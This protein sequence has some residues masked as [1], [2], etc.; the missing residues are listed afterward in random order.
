LAL[1]VRVVGADFAIAAK[2]IEAVL[3]EVAVEKPRKEVSRDEMKRLWE[4]SQPL[5][6]T[7]GE[8]YFRRRGLDSVPSCLR[9]TTKDDEGA[10]ILARV[11]GPTGETVNLHRTFIDYAGMKLP[12]ER[13][14][15]MMPHK[16]PV[17]CAVRL[18]PVSP[19]MG[20][21]EG[22]ENALS[23]WLLKGVPCWATTGTSFLEGFVIPAG[24]EE[25]VIFGDNDKNF[26]GQRAAYA[27]ANRAVEVDKLK[28]VRV[29]LPPIAGKDWN[30]M[31]RDYSEPTA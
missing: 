30:D 18:C 8:R 25:L 17:G 4:G 28:V 1:A 24:V 16:T 7:P 3:G 6:G 29:E 31:L 22:I 19:R 13:P 26:A 2:R 9:Y 21:A 20:V 11:S 15:R 10:C 14:K 23:A 27:R 5:K 12:I